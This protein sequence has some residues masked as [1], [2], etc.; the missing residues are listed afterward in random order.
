MDIISLIEKANPNLVIFCA[1]TL[2]ALISWLLK[3]LVENPIAESKATFH[4]YID[5][6]IEILTEIKTRLNFIAYFPEEKDSKE[7]KNQIQEIILKDGRTGYLNKKTYAS[8]LKI[9]IDPKTNEELLLETIRNIDEELYLQISK[10]QD[11]I[12][13]YRRFSNYNPLRK[14][15]G[16]ILLS[17]QYLVAL[18]FVVVL[19]SLFIYSL[20]NTNILGNI[21]V[22]LISGLLIFLLNKWF[23]KQ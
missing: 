16:L 6:R 15:I 20:T 10:I 1:T 9:S 4:K 11:E 7:F 23:I 22:F 3:S 17:I 19:I 12:T 14:S 2:I 5:K 13:F 18:I 8:V 21:I